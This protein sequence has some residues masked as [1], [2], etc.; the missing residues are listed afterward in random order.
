MQARPETS[1]GRDRNRAGRRAGGAIGVD[2]AAVLPQEEKG[3]RR[4]HGRDTRNQERD[5]TQNPTL[6]S[7]STGGQ[8][9]AQPAPHVVRNASRD[10]ASSAGFRPDGTVA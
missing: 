4:L 7:A 1:F 5:S 2:Q 3:P 10:A 8:V 6:H 9:P